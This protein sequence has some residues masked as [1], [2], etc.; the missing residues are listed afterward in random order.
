MSTEAPAPAPR[1]RARKVEKKSVWQME[2]GSKK[3]T[4]Q[5]G[6]DTQEDRVERPPFE[7]TLPLVNL[8]PKA[9]RE[10]MAIA[11]IRKVLLLFGA[12]IL[13]AA[14]GLW[15]L[16]GSQISQAE[17][18]LAAAQAD[19]Q[20]LQADLEAL[21]PVKQMYEQIT[22]LQELVTSTLAAQPQAALVIE[23]LSAAGEAAGG[24]DV[25]FTNAAVTYT[26]I[27]AAGGE[28]NPC[29]NPNP[30]DVEI[31]VGCITFSA[32]AANRQ[33]VSELLR[34][35]EA[36]PLFVGP[37]VTNSTV[38]DIEG[39]ADSVAFSGSA[40]VSL[41]ALETELTP[42]QEQAILTPPAPEPAPTASTAPGA[43]S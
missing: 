1:R 37:Y 40:G 30:F 11:R 35:L 33:Q 32:S 39:A 28:L 17:S 21:A 42:E 7:P 36:D 15:Y 23:R 38:T 12:L 18:T 6:T 41:T 16:Q 2:L 10:S 25:N 29:P 14:G 27:P 3:S 43:T 9:I 4:A 22:R 19:N 34:L 24:K 5:K 20:Q 8:L 13:I 31:A 26:G